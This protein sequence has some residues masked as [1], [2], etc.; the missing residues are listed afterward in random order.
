MT[1]PTFVSISASPRAFPSTTFSCSSALI[2]TTVEK[3]RTLRLWCSMAWTLISLA[4]WL[5]PAQ[6]GS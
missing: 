5:L 3:K 6:C 2:N 4:V 1:K